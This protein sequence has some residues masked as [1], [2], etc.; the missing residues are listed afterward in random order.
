M[1]LDCTACQC[2]PIGQFWLVLLL[3]SRKHLVIGQF[4]LSLNCFS[5][6]TIWVVNLPEWTEMGLITGSDQTAWTI[7]GSLNASGSS[8][9]TLSERT[10]KS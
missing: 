5:L 9:Y 1:S 3:V 8:Q 7:A 6:V 2:W 4:S 10:K